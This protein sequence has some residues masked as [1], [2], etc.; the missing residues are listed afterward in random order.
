MTV[1]RRRRAA[2]AVLLPE[3]VDR[4][5][6]CDASYFAILGPNCITPPTALPCLRLTCRLHYGGGHF[7]GS[8][9]RARRPW[10]GDFFAVDRRQAFRQLQ[11][12]FA[13]G[14]V[15]TIEVLEIEDLQKKGVAE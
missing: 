3:I 7:G 15:P 5:A 11:Q 6:D 12:H 14:G 10:I 9:R 13:G 8:P 4:R 2:P 1:R